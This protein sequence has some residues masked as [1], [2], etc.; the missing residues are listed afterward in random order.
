MK[1]KQKIIFV[2][3]VEF[4]VKA[5]LLSHLKVLSDKFD[6]TVVVNSNNLNFLSEN[7]IN[8]KLVVVPFKR[9][10]NVFYD[11]YCLV[12]LICLFLK[13]KPSAV[14]S[15][16]P[17]AGLLGMLAAFL[18]F[19]PLKLHT[20]T[21]QVWSNKDGFVRYLLK[22][23]DK[24]IGA[25]TNFNIVDS[26]SQR[27]FLIQENVLDNS[28]CVVFGLGSVAGVDLN[29]FKINQFAR[30][31]IR[32]NLQIPKDAFVFIYLGRLNKDKGIYELLE[33]FGQIKKRDLFLILIG[34]DED[35]FT[36]KIKQFVNVNLSRIRVLGMTSIPADYLSASDV[37]CLPSHREGFG[38]VIIE[39]AA[40][41]IP[42][43]AS[44]IYGI[45]DAVIDGE[46]GL[47]HEAKNVDQI[48]RCM[49]IL[50][51]DSDMVSRLGFSARK[52]VVSEFDSKIISKL[53]FDF[54]LDKL[55]PLQSKCNKQ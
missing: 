37:L 10:I 20:F 41:G 22:T 25:L 8:A 49:E 53:W 42:T 52:R 21:G 18:T 40:V 33:A 30:N 5:F 15:I 34:P 36:L 35:N 19:T 12:V 14:H 9:N 45:S 38:S 7:S 55:N 16:T 27:D 4:A 31:S 46:T 28:K 44:N 1:D 2:A 13:V 6:L 48:K 43:I 23:I 17:K 11:L 47:L 51:N 3:T 24:F 29:K 54:Y 32:E 39:A 26:P 50:S